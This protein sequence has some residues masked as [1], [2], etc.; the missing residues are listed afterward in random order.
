M[1]RVACAQ[2]FLLLRHPDGSC[3][4]LVVADFY[5]QR[6]VPLDREVAPE[7]MRVDAGVKPQEL[8]P[9]YSGR[10]VLLRSITAPLIRHASRTGPQERTMWLFM[11][12]LPR[13]MAVKAVAENDDPFRQAG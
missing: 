6:I 7:L 5:Q 4:R 12:Y 1:P 11:P 2:Q 3:K 13:S 10:A 9:Q 8:Q